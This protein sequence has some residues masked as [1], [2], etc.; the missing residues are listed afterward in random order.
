[1]N[2]HLLAPDSFQYLRSGEKCRNNMHRWYIVQSKSRK[3][4]FLCRQLNHIGIEYYYPCIR[5]KRVNPRARKFQAYFPGYVFIHADVDEIGTSTLQW[6]PGA[7]GIVRFGGEPAY[8]DDGLFH[9]IRQ[10]VDKLNLNGTISK[11]KYKRGDRIY[12]Q[13]GPFIGYEAIFDTHIPGTERVKVL[14]KLVEDRQVRMEIPVEQI[15]L[16]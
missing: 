7:I 15:E 8:I 5:V 9:E 16:K 13:N 2:V 11:E 14:L 10:R 3:E 1:M 12:I 6:M 4:E